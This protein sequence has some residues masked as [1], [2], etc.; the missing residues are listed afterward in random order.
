MIRKG[1]SLQI[2]LRLDDE[3]PA[4]PYKT[5]A[6]EGKVLGQG[7]PLGGTSKVGDAGD[8]DGPLRVY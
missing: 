5:R 2:V 8:D 4:G 7:E 3:T 1:E 6:G